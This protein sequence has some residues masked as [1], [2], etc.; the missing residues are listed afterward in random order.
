[1]TLGNKIG[2][3]NRICDKNETWKHYIAK[4]ILHKLIIDNKYDSIIEYN[5]GSR[6]IDVLQK[7]D[8]FKWMGYELQTKDTKRKK[9]EM[10][11]FVETHAFFEDVIV[12]DASK[13]P[14]DFE[15]MKKALKERII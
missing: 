11:E 2:I 7:L 5:A 9:A 14:N 1:M 3:G 10:L 12:I 8:T 4:C 13:L 15:G 6:I